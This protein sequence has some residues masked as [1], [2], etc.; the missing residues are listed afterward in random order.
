VI[1]GELTI[2]GFDLTEGDGLSFLDENKIDI[3][4]SSN[5]EIILFDLRKDE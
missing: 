1:S 3:S 5:S 2:N 4:N